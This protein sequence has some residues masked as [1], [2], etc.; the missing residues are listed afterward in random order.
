MMV[1]SSQATEKQMEIRGIFMTDIKNVSPQVWWIYES[2][3]GLSGLTLAGRSEEEQLALHY[4]STQRKNAYFAEPT[5]KKSP[6]AATDY[7]AEE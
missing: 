3:Q 7:F 2:R 1:K 6:Q 4:T 5:K